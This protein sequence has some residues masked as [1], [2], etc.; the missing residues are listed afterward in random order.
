MRNV[1]L[2][3]GVGNKKVKLRSQ[4]SL[5]EKLPAKPFDANRAFP[6]VVVE[7]RQLIASSFFVHQRNW[8]FPAFLTLICVAARSRSPSS[9]PIAAPLMSMSS[10]QRISSLPTSS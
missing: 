8:R 7:Q 5:L 9:I 10:G 1:D 2:E 3:L 4:S 6:K